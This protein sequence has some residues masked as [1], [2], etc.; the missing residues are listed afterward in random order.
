MVGS[1]AN[2]V[3]VSAAEASAKRVKN[4]RERMGTKESKGE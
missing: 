4:T 2:Q 3:L 1:P